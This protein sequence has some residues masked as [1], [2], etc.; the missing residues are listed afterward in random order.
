[1]VHRGNRKRRGSGVSRLSVVCLDRSD[2]YLGDLRREQK[3]F[4]HFDVLAVHFSHR[5]DDLLVRL[6]RVKA[7]GLE[8]RFKVVSR[9]QQA[10]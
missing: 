5:G 7:E 10:A 9:L 8:L 1:M 2:A 4:R 3:H 6:E